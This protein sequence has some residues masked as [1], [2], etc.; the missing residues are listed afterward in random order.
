MNMKTIVIH[1]KEESISEKNK[2]V[3]KSIPYDAFLHND[4]NKQYFDYFL[5]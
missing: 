5:C 2:N 4:I 1:L 3:G